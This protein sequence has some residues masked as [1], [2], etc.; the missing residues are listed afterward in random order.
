LEPRAPRDTY[1]LRTCFADPARA[2]AQALGELHAAVDD[3]SRGT[4]QW[5]VVKVATASIYVDALE[6]CI[7]PLLRLVA[8]DDGQDI[9]VLAGPAIT[10]L[11]AHAFAVGAWDESQRWHQRAIDLS[12]G[13]GIELTLYPHHYRLGKVAALR[14][15][16][17]KA[18]ECVEVVTRWATSRR[19]FGAFS[20]VR[21]VQALLAMTAGDYEAAYTAA[22]AVSRP[23][24]F[25]LCEPHAIELSLELVEACVHTGRRAEAKAHVEEMRR[26]NIARLSSR[27][28]LRVAGCMAI[29]AAPAEATALYEVALATPDSAGWPYETARI[30]LAYG[31]HLRRTK[32]SAADAR[33][34]LTEALE[35]FDR[36]GAEP[37]CARASAELRALGTTRTH[38]SGVGPAALTPQEREIAMLAATGLTNKEI[39]ARVYLSARTVGAHLYHAYPKLGIASRAALRDALSQL[40]DQRGG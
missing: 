30:R 5:P 22:S 18:E 38:R 36:M 40:E 35:T 33:R 27:C 11:G 15:D 1:L 14:G 32:G 2:D 12:A 39:A 23:G 29:A 25:A 24:Q 28:A 26:L 13:R 21:H 4:E 6:G 34:Q 20:A 37:W 8:P 19:A 3:L 17:R 7:E 31:Q 16:T 9:A 10:C